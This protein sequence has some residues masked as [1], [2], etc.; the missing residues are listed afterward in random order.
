MI[1][2]RTWLERLL[3]VAGIIAA[4]CMDGA[5]TSSVCFLSSAAADR[6]IREHPEPPESF[7]QRKELEQLLL[8][9]QR[10]ASPQL[11]GI[12]HWDLLGDSV[13]GQRRGKGTE[14]V[15]RRSR[16]PCTQ[17]ADALPGLPQQRTNVAATKATTCPPSFRPTGGTDPF[18]GFATLILTLRHASS[19]WTGCAAPE[20]QE[21]NSP[22]SKTAAGT[23]RVEW[24]VLLQLCL[25]IRI[26]SLSAT[27]CQQHLAGDVERGSSL[28]ACRE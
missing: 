22:C 8:Q 28:A 7:R 2:A 5:E 4:G 27:G 24:S 20:A 1:Q 9:R 12:F 11:L 23:Q 13:A 18:R 17:Q 15:L 25:L 21:Q 10:S 14:P 19:L 16:P 6:T 3:A 26:L